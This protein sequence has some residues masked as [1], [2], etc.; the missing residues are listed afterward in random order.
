MK[1]LSDL[2]R[3]SI[4][5]NQSP[6]KKRAIKAGCIIYMQRRFFVCNEPRWLDVGLGLKINISQA[7]SSHYRAL[8]LPLSF[9]T[10]LA[11]PVPK[12]ISSC[13]GSIT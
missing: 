6:P 12:P 4:A 11:M 8:R 10:N 2:L 1:R 5:T 7:K 9:G 3:A 13:V